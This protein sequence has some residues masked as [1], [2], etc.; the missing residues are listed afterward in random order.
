MP[1]GALVI[2]FD[3]EMAWGLRR[4]ALRTDALVGVERVRDVVDGLLAIFREH[5]ISATWATIGHLMVRSKDCVDGRFPI[6][7]PAPHYDWF[8]GGW[9]DRIPR[10]DEPGA[11]RFYA[12]DLIEKLLASPVY[13]ELGAHTFTHVMVGHPACTREIARA[14]F[15]ACQTLARGWGRTLR[16]VV[17]PWNRAGHLSVLEETGFACYRAINSE[18]YWFGAAEKIGTPL[19]QSA[20]RRVARRL[21]LPLRWLDERL[22]VAPPLPPAR[23]VGRLWEIPHSMFFSGFGGVGRFVSTADRVAKAIKGLQAAAERGRIFSLYTHPENFLP[24]PHALL[25]AFGAICAAAAKLR[26]AGEIRILP[27]ESVA[28]EL[29]AGAGAGWLSSAS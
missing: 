18:W 10:V 9:L 13:Q 11:D 24:D 15:D 27:M 16:S 21:T 14:E 6:G 12:P 25:E 8:Q 19:G 17:F 22:R 5:A 26:D 3:F 29:D 2:S 20:A 28:A 7:W 23:R 4:S 1:G